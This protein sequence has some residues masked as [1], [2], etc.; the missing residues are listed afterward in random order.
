MEPTKKRAIFQSIIAV[1]AVVVM[2]G[3]G[4]GIYKIKF[5]PPS[6]ES[7]D[8]A[9][10]A[11]DYKRVVQLMERVD[12]EQD[13][14]R[15]YFIYAESL[16]ALG[17]KDEALKMYMKADD[18]NY[19]RVRVRFAIGT[20]Y[21]EKGEDYVAQHWL[22]DVTDLG[23]SID[24]FTSIGPET[25]KIISSKAWDEFLKADLIRQDKDVFKVEFFDGSWIATFSRGANADVKYEMLFKGAA[26]KETTTGRNSHEALYVKSEQD[27]TWDYTQTDSFGRLSIGKARIT[28]HLE[29]TGTVSYLDGTTIFFRTEARGAGNKLD[30]TRFESR[31][32][33]KTWDVVNT[34]QL[35]KHNRDENETSI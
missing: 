5:E 33:G 10:A 15:N 17:D 14:G 19:E 16:K 6:Q 32:D 7:L 24:G 28:D 34:Y 21:A 30:F 29:I 13:A 25:Q 4:Y 1:C 11:T 35:I 2:A 12:L 22:K 9:F 3:V 18:R 23:F 8:E 27:G 26:L 20:I 31:D